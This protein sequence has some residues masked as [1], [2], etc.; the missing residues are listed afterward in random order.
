MRVRFRKVHGAGNDFVLIIGAADE[1][2]WRA[3]GPRLCA[4][5]T[6]V[7]ADG[8]VVSSAIR[9]DSAVLDVLCVNADGSVATLCANALRCVA[10]CASRDHGWTTMR[11]VM[12]GVPHDAV[13]DGTHVRVTVEAGEVYSERVTET[14]PGGTVRFDAVHVG[15]EHLVALVDDVD[16]LDVESLVNLVRDRGPAAADANVSVF[17]LLGPQE[18][19]I[20]TY[21]R[22][23][24]GEALSCA[25]GAVAAAVAAAR[26]G[27]VDVARQVRVHNRA[28][29]PLTVIE[30]AERPSYWVGGPVTH[31]FDGELEVA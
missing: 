17:Q 1:R 12:S 6:G 31:V 26:R 18:L 21:E 15:A 27:L 8:L 20:R 19:T 3:W 29:T 30:H 28:G 13:V 22:G 23:A 10:W 2:D 4:R 11:L 16:Q 25:S 7:G 14:W 24:E 5:C 9:K